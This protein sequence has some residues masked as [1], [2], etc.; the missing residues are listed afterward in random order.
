MIIFSPKAYQKIKYFVRNTPH[1]ISG[2]GKSRFIDNKTILVQDIEI[3]KQENSFAD[4]ILDEA[5]MAEFLQEKI[6]ESES[7][8]IW[9]HSH[10]DMASF[11]SVTDEQT[12]EETTGGNYLISLVIN[13]KLKTLARFDLFKPLRV[14]LNLSVR[15]SKGRSKES[16]Q[17]LINYCKNRLKKCIKKTKTY[18]F[19]NYFPNYDFKG[20]QNFLTPKNSKK[21]LLLSVEE[22]LAQQ[23]LMD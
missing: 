8:N 1:E 16:K 13:K 18:T 20:S 6:E 2:M 9:W 4:T 21:Q 5:A 19:P 12:I 14:T 10:A 3:L 22:I 11:W 7:W 15:K 23:Q 17:Y